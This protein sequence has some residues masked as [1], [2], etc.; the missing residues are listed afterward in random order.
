LDRAEAKDCGLPSA[1]VRVADVLIPDSR[2]PLYE[3]TVL[4]LMANILGR[5][6]LN[7]ITVD[8]DGMLIAGAHRLEAF[9][10]LGYAKIVCRV[11]RR[12]AMSLRGSRRTE[13]A[14]SF[15]RAELSQQERDTLLAEYVVFMGGAG[16]AV[17]IK[18]ERGRVGAVLRVAKAT[19]LSKSTVQ[20]AINR[21]AGKVRKKPA[22]GP[23]EPAPRQQ[24]EPAGP[25]EY[26]LRDRD[27]HALK[28]VQAIWNS[29]SAAQ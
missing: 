18:G 13:I 21:V 22:A 20:R 5:G 8:A 26:A 14:E 15:G 24:R 23:I 2:R 25:I 17:S 29:A 12:G 4:A 9:K 16:E 1:Y 19:G 27:R 7:P 10:R 28:V 6:L 3:D 11:V